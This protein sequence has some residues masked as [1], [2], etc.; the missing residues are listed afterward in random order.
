MDKES[1]LWSSRF[2]Q[3]PLF[4]IVKVPINQLIVMSEYKSADSC[5]YSQLC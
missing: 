3:A 2:S 1:G 4:Y 5:T